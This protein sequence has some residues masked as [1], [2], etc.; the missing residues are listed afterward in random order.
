M[1]SL[2][3]VGVVVVLFVVA[4]VLFFAW[5]NRGTAQTH[6]RFQRADVE[7]VLE[8]FLAPDPDGTYDDWDLFLH[9][10]IKASQLDAIRL[11][12]RRITEESASYVDE[13]MRAKVAAV[14][15]KLR[16]GT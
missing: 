14:L 1:E 3:A 5:A 12:C 9:W 7:A 15:A 11:E 6:E 4:V 13:D 16:H 10:P 8:G 2:S